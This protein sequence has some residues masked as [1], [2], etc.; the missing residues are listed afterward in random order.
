VLQA[1]RRAAYCAV[2]GKKYPKGR[3]Q[4]S[5]AGGFESE[6]VEGNLLLEPTNIKGHTAIRTGSPLSSNRNRLSGH[7]RARMPLGSNCTQAISSNQLRDQH[8]ARWSLTALRPGPGHGPNS[9]SAAADSESPSRGPGPGP[10][11][12]GC[13]R[14]GLRPPGAA[15]A[16]GCGRRGLRPPG[17]RVTVTVRDP[18]LRVRLPTA[19]GKLTADPARRRGRPGVRARLRGQWWPAT[20]RHA[21]RPGSLSQPARPGGHVPQWPARGPHCQRLPATPTALSSTTRGSKLKL[22]GRSSGD[23]DS[24]SD[25]DSRACPSACDPPCH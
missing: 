6:R 18:S 8:P 23:S 5:E 22:K 1:E 2:S 13:G 21:G 11:A 15:A 12:G 24:D 25:S 10:A 19:S 9:S 14:R 17:V 16:G 4:Q 3:Q 20:P 7:S